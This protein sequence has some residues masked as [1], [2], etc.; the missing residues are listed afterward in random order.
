MTS[1]TLNQ[2]LDARDER[3][4]RQKN[5]LNRFNYPLIS[6]TMNIAGPIKTSPLIERSF[7]EGI[8]LLK[9]KLPKGS[10]I[11]QEIITQ[12]TGCEA[13]FSVNCDIQ[14][15]K[16]IC[17]HIE[18]SVSIGRLFDMDVINTD[19]IKLEREN[20]R[21]CFVCKSPGRFCAATRA[22]PVKELQAVTN[23][24]MEIYFFLTDK[25][26][27]SSLAVK[28]LLDEVYTTPK[29]GLV[30]CRNNG[31]HTDMDI[32]TFE[33][34]AHALKPY[35]D[36]CFSIGKN[37]CALSPDETFL[38]LRSA[39]IIAEKTM[40]EATCGVNTH[41][42]AIYSIGILCAAIGRLWLPQAPFR[43]I[44]D[45]CS[46]CANMVKKAV[47]EDFKQIDTTTAGGRLYL[48]YG[49]TGIRG[50]AATGFESV[51]KISLPCYKSFSNK[52]FS[53]N[54]AGAITL[55]HLISSVKDTNL[56]H[57]GGTEGAEYAMQTA[58]QLLTDC[59][60]P[61]KK[62]IESIDDAFIKRNLSPGGCADLLAIT[63]FLYSLE[64]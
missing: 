36:E 52:N 34:S 53:P 19:G 11:H 25:E 21:S 50:E 18:E 49:L 61:T 14:T 6:F 57:R 27:V 40:F 41:K 9:E 17:T 1:V 55:L 43:S 59:P 29:P 4:K 32:N 28:S 5:T 47:I 23:E 54:D 22:H 42:G 30:D 31:S 33:K 56:Y 26:K 7:F 64:Q 37:T 20:P 39:G 44:C 48:K 63:Y 60:E 2:I 13:I 10:I 15:L 46:E 16:A 45:I 24:I 62:Q 38:K 35:F 3:A 58:R 12:P 51:T 8:H